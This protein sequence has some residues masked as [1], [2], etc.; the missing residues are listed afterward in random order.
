MSIQ[1]GIPGLRELNL[2]S[3]QNVLESI[4]Q[5]FAL[6][7]ARLTATTATAGQN[8]LTL[9]QSNASLSNL[10]SQ[11]NVLE[12]L[13]AALSAVSSGPTLMLRADEALDAG[14]PV[15][16]SSDGGCAAV[17]P[18]DP[19]KISGV[20][21]VTETSAG[22]GGSVTVRQ[23]GLLTIM[24]AA[25]DSGRA[26]Y[27]EIGGVSQSPNYVGVVIPVGVAVTS[28][29]MYV[30]VGH[31]SLKLTSF[32][33]GFEDLLPVTYGVIA[34]T[35]AL[36]D[37]LFAQTDGLVEWSG[38]VLVTRNPGMGF[39]YADDSTS[40]PFGTR[41]CQVNAGALDV[42]I[43]LFTSNEILPGE[44]T[45]VTIKRVDEGSA[46]GPGFVVRIAAST[47]EEIDHADLYFLENGESVSL[48]GVNSAGWQ[49]A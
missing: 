5:R 36:L 29:T 48:F 14:Q 24:G 49:S 2:R 3:I 31:A 28:T 22:T 43:T 25:F 26:V 6:V 7:E 39:I 19:E 45:V 21:G 11:I 13:V 20:L 35:L 41:Y 42:D 15:Y 8:G 16:A 34:E 38:G 23:A 33:P 10:Q 17:D 46:T 32:D 30:N 37:T 18:T 27:A 9:S 1:G 44:T 40:L 47:G 12:S 4:R